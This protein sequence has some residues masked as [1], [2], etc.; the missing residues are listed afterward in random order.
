MKGPID[1]QIRQMIA[2]NLLPM[3]GDEAINVRVDIPKLFVSVPPT[4]IVPPLIHLLSDKDERKRSV[5][6]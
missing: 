2:T 4:F 3:V 5:A 1:K 6:S